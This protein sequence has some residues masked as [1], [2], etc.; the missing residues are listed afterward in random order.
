MGANKQTKS[1]YDQILKENAM[2]RYVPL[3]RITQR[4]GTV[5]WLYW[6]H[7]NRINLVGIGWWM[8]W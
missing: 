8:D 6:R 3:C 4:S 5:P 1:F 2:G 7:L